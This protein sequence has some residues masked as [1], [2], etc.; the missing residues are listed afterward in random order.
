MTACGIAHVI[1]S[2]T[3]PAGIFSLIGIRDYVNEDT[4]VQ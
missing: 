2:S 3:A 4:A 1:F